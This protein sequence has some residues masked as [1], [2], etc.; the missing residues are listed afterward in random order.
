MESMKA[1]KSKVFR[2]FRGCV[3]LGIWAVVCFLAV[4]AAMHTGNRILPKSAGALILNVYLYFLVE[5][6][7]L[8][9]FR[10]LSAV[11]V[12]GAVFSSLF[13]AANLYVIEFRQIP[14]YATDLTTVGT[15]MQVAGEY[16]Y[17]L[18]RELLILAG[19]IVAAVVLGIWLERRRK[20]NGS[21]RRTGWRSYLAGLLGGV[22]LVA[23]SGYMLWFSPLL[24][25]RIALR[26]NRPIQSYIDSGGLLIFAKSFKVLFVE[27]PE[28]YSAA[29]IRRIEETYPAENPGE[30][31]EAAA[32]GEKSV[33]NQAVTTRTP[34]VIIVMNEALA[35]LQQT[36]SFETSEEVL[37]FLSGLTE[38]TVS[39]RC[40]VSVFGGH[41]ANSEYEVLTGDSMAYLPADI[42]PYQM[43]VKHDMASLPRE[44]AEKGYRTLAMHPNA[45]S[46]YQRN[47]VYQHFGIERFLTIDDFEQTPENLVRRL[48][49]DQADVSR[50]IAE[51]EDCRAQGDEPY[52]MFNVTMQNHSSYS[53]AFDNLP[54]TIEITT[55]NCQDEEAR[56]YLNLIRLTDAAMQALIEY[57]EQIEEPT[58]ILL[59]GDHQPGLS[60]KFYSTI[61]GKEVRALSAEE[62]LR[63]RY[64]TPYWIW[65]NYDIEEQT[66][67]DVSA[68]YLQML[69]KETAGME[70]TP[71]DRFLQRLSRE[72]PVITVQGMIDSEDRYHRLQ[73]TEV[74][75]RQMLKDYEMLVYN[76]LFD[77]KNPSDWF[78]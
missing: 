15:A 63:S 78:Q 77:R 16:E 8:V 31:E 27:K 67:R 22:L 57:F 44:L 45:G 36:G 18:K 5:L 59:F 55:E 74:A 52:F 50:I 51:Y 32:S 39:G 61:L 62:E 43:Y 2:L 10:R 72:M 73:D 58:V 1:D 28:G 14:I 23:G 68:N 24:R 19:L 33:G 37:P 38:N 11:L 70:L 65:A 53:S 41:T 6:V 17:R 47:A 56:R 46:N 35:D 4:E 48:I 66:G 69:L 40:Y 3:L 7:F 64:W 13:A 30:P 60:E 76:H 42:T 12:G 20:K 9:L 75:C 29:E 54:E 34:N 49:S 26:N 21:H 71:Y 25:N